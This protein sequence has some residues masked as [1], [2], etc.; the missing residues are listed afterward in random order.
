MNHWIISLGFVLSGCLSLRWKNLQAIRARCWKMVLP[1][2]YSQPAEPG[3]GGLKGKR[4]S[5]PIG[6]SLFDL[7]SDLGEE[8]NV[9]DVN[10]NVVKEIQTLARAA[11]EDLGDGKRKGQGA[12]R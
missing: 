2:S 1:H 10:P 4:G 7:D 11:R 3:N 12:R 6:L 8:V 9:A 5:K